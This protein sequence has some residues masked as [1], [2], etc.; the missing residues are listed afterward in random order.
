[1]NW[2]GV[3]VVVPVYQSTSTLRALVDRVA[4][5]LEVLGPYEVLL[6]DDGS[7]GATWNVIQDLSARNP[8]TIGV[9]L[10]RNYGQQSALIAGIREASF[11]VTVTIDDDLQHPPEEIPN[12]VMAL[13]RNNLDV[14]YGFPEH[15]R[16]SIARRLVSRLHRIVLTRSLGVDVVSEG[17]SF[18]AFRTR[19]RDAF[20]GELG[21]NVSLDAL[22]TWSSSR[23]GS[24]PVRHDPRTVGTSNYTFGRLLRFAIDSV[25]GYSALPL[26]FASILGFATAAFGLAVLMFVTVRPL[27]AGDSVPGF[28]FLAATIAIFSGV[29]L[30]TLGVIGEYLARMHFRVMRKPTY[31]ISETTRQPSDQAWGSGSRPDDI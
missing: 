22:L 24:I 19:A 20:T 21:T 28:P 11:P 26:Q 1:M 23:F 8:Q 13:L 7:R 3:S 15:V 18:R 31:V 12:L 9:R 4:A 14:V 27:L 5:A 16:Q 30:L 6:V 10:S 2:P 17:T 29:Q 25:T